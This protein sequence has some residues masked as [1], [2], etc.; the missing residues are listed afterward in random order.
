MTDFKRG[1]KLKFKTGDELGRYVYEYLGAEFGGGTHYMY[2]TDEGHDYVYKTHDIGQYV[3]YVPT[4]EVGKKYKR[5]HSD[6]TFEPKFRN[7]DE[8][9]GLVT[10]AN[11]NDTW[12][13]SRY[14]DDFVDYEE[15]S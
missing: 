2:D 13:A 4:F 1:D 10:N 6:A 11:G 9:S 8:V 7:K 12:I 14:D 5:K 3:R 15:I